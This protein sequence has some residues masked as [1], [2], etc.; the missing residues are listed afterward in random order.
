VSDSLMPLDPLA[1]LATAAPEPLRAARVKARCQTRLAAR[2]AP[3]PA[4][5]R[6]VAGLAVVRVWQPLV[7]LL[8]IG[9]LAEVV[10]EALRIY[11]LR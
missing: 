1:R 5:P 2:W 6:P 10:V 4:P 7:V 11:G 3:R 9:Y 8:G